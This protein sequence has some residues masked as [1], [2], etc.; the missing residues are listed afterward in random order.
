MALMNNH[1]ARLLNKLTTDLPWLPQ[2]VRFG[3]V[4]VTAAAIHFAIVVLLVQKAGLAPLVAN[5]FGFLISFQASY[6]GHRCWTFQGTMIVHTIAFPKLLLVQVLNL[7]ANEALFYVF[8]ACDLPY[9][10]ALLIVL[11]ILPLYTFVISKVW[12]F[13]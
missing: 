3:L 5:I 6:W 8:L 13:N 7:A 2:L 11:T 9:P 12:V 10:V 4:G 1:I